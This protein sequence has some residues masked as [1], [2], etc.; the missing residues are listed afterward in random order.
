MI[1]T[2]LGLILLL[3]LIA[4]YIVVCCLEDKVKRQKEEYLNTLDEHD[5]AVICVYIQKGRYFKKRNKKNDEQ[6]ED[7]KD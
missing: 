7:S 6:K 2:V 1:E 5:K 4:F 3:G